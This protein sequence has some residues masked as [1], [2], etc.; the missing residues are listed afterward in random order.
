[1][2]LPRELVA[3]VLSHPLLKGLMATDVGYFPRAKGHLRI[4]ERGVEQAIFIYCAKGV[5]GCEMEGRTY[6][7]QIGRA[8][9]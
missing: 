6:E 4:R 8:H 1:M 3:S 2:V 7:V 5:G 9:V